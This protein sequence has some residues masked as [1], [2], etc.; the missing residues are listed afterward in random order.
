MRIANMHVKKAENLIVHRDEIM[1]RPARTFI[2]KNKNKVEE[3][4]KTQLKKELTPEEQKCIKEQLF[5][6]RISKRGAKPKRIRAYQE[7][8]EKKGAGKAKKK[9]PNAAPAPGGKPAAGQHATKTGRSFD[10][11]LT[12]TSKKSV[13]ALR[14]KEYEKKPHFG[15]KKKKGAFKSK[16]KHKRR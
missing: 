1:S 9:K 4:S 2:D 10:S 15:V 8:E 6:K 7:D 3:K 13:K 12:D 14:Y 16:G 11:E 5:L